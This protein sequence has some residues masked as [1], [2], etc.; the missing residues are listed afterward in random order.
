MN[1]KLVSKIFMLTLT[2]AFSFCFYGPESIADSN[3]KVKV[4][5]GFIQS[6]FNKQ[7]VEKI[8]NSPPKCENKQNTNFLTKEVNKYLVCHYNGENIK[9]VYKDNTVAHIA[10]YNTQGLSYHRD[11]LKY[12][13]LDVKEPTTTNNFNLRWKNYNKDLKDVAFFSDDDG[14]IR[15]AFFLYKDIF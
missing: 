4:N 3:S 2:L 10:I 14:N 13:G 6:R 8:I 15:Y 9:V 11:S 5:I 12:F 7:S 1:N